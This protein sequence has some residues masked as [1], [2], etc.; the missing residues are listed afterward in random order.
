MNLF[1]IKI[2]SNLEFHMRFEVLCS[3]RKNCTPAML[4]F[5]VNLCRTI[6]KILDVVT[7]AKFMDLAKRLLPDASFY[8]CCKTIFSNGV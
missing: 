3:L 1:Y 2:V 6:L 5:N 4:D 8:F 7:R